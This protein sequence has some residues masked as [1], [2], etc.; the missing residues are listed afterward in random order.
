MSLLLFVPSLNNVSG[1]LICMIISL[2]CLAIAAFLGNP[3]T[4]AGAPF[5]RR[6]NWGWAGMFFYVLAV[7]IS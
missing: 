3:A 5:Y 7:A 2:L 4:D 1:A 6:L